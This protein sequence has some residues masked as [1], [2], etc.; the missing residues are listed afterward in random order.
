M[1]IV[2]SYNWKTR[3]LVLT[4]LIL[5]LQSYNLLQDKLYAFSILF[6]LWHIEKE[7]KK[8]D[9]EE[10]NVLN[11]IFVLHRHYCNL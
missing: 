11:T 3:N 4:G 2:T 9:I 8:I 5:M 10:T 6:K 1:S 7:E